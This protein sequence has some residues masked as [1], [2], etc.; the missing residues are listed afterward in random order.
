MFGPSAAIGT[1]LASRRTLWNVST[2]A[3]ANTSACFNQQHQLP[4]SEASS[5][6]LIHKAG[7]QHKCRSFSP[8]T[9]YPHA[10]HTIMNHEKRAIKCKKII[11][12]HSV[13]FWRL[14]SPRKW[15]SLPVESHRWLPSAR[16]DRGG[17]QTRKRFEYRGVPACP[18]DEEGMLVTSRTR[19]KHTVA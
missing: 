12:C 4:N 16:C 10:R 8:H 18:E 15:R 19:E 17:P 2:P 1:S 11:D 13:H 5:R 9:T 14:F 3:P 6:N 7:A